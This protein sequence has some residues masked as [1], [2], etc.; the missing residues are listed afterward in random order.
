MLSSIDEMEG[1]GTLTR[2]WVPAILFAL[3][4]K[5]VRFTTLRRTL[6]GISQKTL[7]E[8]LRLLERD[9]MIKRDA[10]PTIPPRVE[11]QLSSFGTQFLRVL[12]TLHAFSLESRLTL[13]RNRQRFDQRREHEASNASAPL[14]L[15]R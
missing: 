6:P 9:G 4:S 10:Y 3:D 1:A 14:R 12:H 7:S 5:V 8:T 11:Y 2:K 13:E 15:G